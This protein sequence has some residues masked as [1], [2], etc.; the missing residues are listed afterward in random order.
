[1]LGF[2]VVV[3]FL[4]ML[5]VFGLKALPPA[6]AFLVGGAVILVMLV[7]LVLLPHRIAYVLGWLT[8]LAVVAGGFL[9]GMLFVVGI[10]FTAIWT[11]C[12]VTGIR[13]DRAEA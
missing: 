5:V 9:I 12:M 6:Q 8:Q 11:W 2:E 3:V 4:G 13:L 7:A 1:M 10:I